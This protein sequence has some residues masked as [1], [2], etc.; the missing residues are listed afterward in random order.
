MNPAVTHYPRAALLT[1]LLLGAG[2]LTGCGGHTDAAA[3]D[4]ALNV[5]NWSGYIAPDTVANFQRETG[6]EVHYST[7]ESNEIS[8]T[9][10]L[11]GHSNYDVVTS[12]D[13]FFERQLH[14]GV[15]RK[16]DKRALPNSVN[17]DP[18]VLQKPWTLSRT[19]TLQRDA[20]EE[21]PPCVDY[22]AGHYVNQ[23]HHDN[24]R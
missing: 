22:D 9:K 3:P 11:T 7:Y 17:L 18:E 19:L 23:E 5:Y 16:L 24:G 13:A 1:A 20:L 2:S 4:K 14:A 12:A 6:I 10:L 15:F 8:E 21:A